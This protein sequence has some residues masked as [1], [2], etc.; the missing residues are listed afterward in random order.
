M[1]IYGALLRIPA[2]SGSPG[3]LNCRSVTYIASAEDVPTGHER[4]IPPA[5]PSLLTRSGRRPAGKW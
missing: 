4:T 5:A 3:L 2:P 1:E